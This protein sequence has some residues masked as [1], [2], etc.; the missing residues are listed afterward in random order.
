MACPRVKIRSAKPESNASKIFE[1]LSV[2]PLYEMAAISESSS[3]L[4]FSKHQISIVHVHDDLARQ[5]ARA[6]V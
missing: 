1:G 5:N 4:S 6:E 2:E 3:Q